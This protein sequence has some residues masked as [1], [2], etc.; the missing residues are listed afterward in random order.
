MTLIILTCPFHPLL[1]HLSL[2]G[3]MDFPGVLGDG[4]GAGRS[5]AEGRGRKRER[6]YADFMFGLRS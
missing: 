4:R 5:R 1:V 2:N 3:K 6:R